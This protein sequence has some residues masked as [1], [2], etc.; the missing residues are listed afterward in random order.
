[1]VSN[2]VLKYSSEVEEAVDH[3]R[4]LGL[5]PHHNRV[6]SWDVSKMINIIN[7]GSRNSFVLDVGCNGSPILPMLRRLGFRNLYGCDLSLPKYPPLLLKIVC[8]F[9][10]RNYKPI[11][12]MYENKIY[13]I[14]I[15]DLERTNFQN[16]MFDYITSLSVIE[17]GINLQNYFK[18]MNR[19]L[20]EG[21]ILLTSTDYWPDKVVNKKTNKFSNPKTVH[22]DNIFS[23][24]EIEESVVKVAEQNGFVLT[25][26]IDFAYQDK[27]IHWNASGLDYTFIFF[28]LK[29][30]NPT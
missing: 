22:S 9:Y 29:K 13:H 7:K 24:K 27:V 16:N 10:K 4:S 26:P 30:N 19:I 18:E 12:E 6:K 2:S 17:H 5:Y 20:K 28:T 8:S 15:Q 3:L 21:G 25:E 14:S 23:K 11:I 1:M